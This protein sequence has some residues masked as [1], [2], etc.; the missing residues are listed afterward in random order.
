MEHGL[1]DALSR[2]IW[3]IALSYIIFACNYDYGGFI[4]SFLSHRYWKPLA[5]LSYAIFYMHYIVI[6]ITM[7][8]IKTPPYLDE[9]SFI[10]YGIANCILTIFISVIATLAIESP[11]DCIQKLI[12]GTSQKSGTIENTIED[13]VVKKSD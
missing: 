3:S 8:S 7:G 11:I 5:R 2:V 6:F 9:I 10:V 1:Y 13:K 4:D 12:I